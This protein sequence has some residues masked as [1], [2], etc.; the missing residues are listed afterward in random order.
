MN[1]NKIK[2]ARIQ[3]GLTQKE[4]SET[5]KIPQRTIENWDAGIRRPPEWTEL[6]IVEKLE[7]I[8]R[9][10][11]K[12]AIDEIKKMTSEEI[13]SHLT[14]AVADG[15]EVDIIFSFE[16][17]DIMLRGVEAPEASE[18]EDW[19]DDEPYMIKVISDH[20][21]S[22]SFQIRKSS[23]DDWEDAEEYI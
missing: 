18:E 15:D 21:G 6:L 13:Y 10:K 1:E 22:N 5:L 19:T 20:V 2:E 9:D 3:A 12:N 16:G 7:K 11:M 4:M 23:E 14:W 17:F 8:R